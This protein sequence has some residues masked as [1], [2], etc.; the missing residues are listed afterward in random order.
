MHRDVV[1]NTALLIFS[2]LFVVVVAYQVYRGV[3]A[4]RHPERPIVR[5][6]KTRWHVWLLA[7]LCAY[8]LI[9]WI[10]AQGARVFR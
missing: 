7:F 3:V 6:A 1:G 4:F 8:A 2:G 9:A 10:A 5:P